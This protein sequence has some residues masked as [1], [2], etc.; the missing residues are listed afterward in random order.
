MAYTPLQFRPGIN[1]DITPHANEG[2]WID[3]DKVRFRQGFPETI[4]GW[5][6]V[7]PTTFQG[8]CRALHSWVALDNSKYLGI[9][10]HLKYY[11]LEGQDYY[12]VTPVRVTTAAGDVTFS[13][14][15]ESTT[16]TVTDAGHAAAIGDFVTFSGAVTLGGTVTAAVLNAEHQITAILTG[17]T[18]TFEVTDAAIAA[19]EAGDGGASVVGAYQINTGLDSVAFGNGWGAGVWEADA[20]NPRSS[21][22]G[23]NDSA[24]TTVT[25][26]Q[27]RTWS[28]DNYGEDL[29]FCVRNGGVYYWDRTGALTTRAVA[30]SS[31]SGS[32]LA[33]T[34][35]RVVITSSSDRHA[36]A[37][38]CD[39]EDNIGTQDP[40]LIRFCD[41]EDITEWETR[42]DTT[43]GSIRISSGSEIITAIR[44][45]Q[46]VL[47]LTDISAHVVQYLGAPFTFGVTEIST[48]VTAL[49]PNCAV[50]IGDAVFWMGDGDFHVYDGTVQQIS[51]P[52]LEYVFSNFNRSQKNKVACGNNAEHS[53]VWWF[54]PSADSTTNDRYVVYN[55]QEQLWYYGSMAR[56]AWEQAGVFLDSIA[57]GTDNYLY[58]Q[59]VGINDGSENPPVGISSY[60][61]S[62]PVDM[63]AGD[64][65]LFADRVIPDVTFRSSTGTPSATLTIKAKDWPGGG[66][67]TKEEDGAVT[68]SASVPVE[69]YTKEQYIR[70]RA[71]AMSLRFESDQ[72]NTSWR[73]GIPRINIR[74][75]GRA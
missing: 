73:L 30:L 5:E 17:N 49:G 72:Y 27:L 19:D 36:M 67:L 10:T 35:A 6:K 11:I 13:A 32:N 37:F 31:L 15:D 63:D 47:V 44:T 62:S 7:A 58:Y 9:G 46:Q 65:Y 21:T 41:Q 66:Y 61:E 56:T 75:D 53:E 25:S 51:C 54:Y 52:V 38:G 69:K 43:A 14:T 16:I 20:T 42:A 4:G 57:A 18:Y 39:P 29:L 40:L 59:E 71:R 23:W 24:D 70:L 45:R 55:Y 50:S 22:R 28:H 64:R 26:S 33:P 2:G 48:A 74:P 8:T 12:D 1:R 34:I 68:R 3:C 60:I